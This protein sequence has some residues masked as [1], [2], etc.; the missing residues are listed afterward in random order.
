ML[1]DEPLGV[2]APVPTAPLAHDLKRTRVKATA[3]STIGGECTRP[4][5]EYSPNMELHCE[6]I[7]RSKARGGML[8]ESYRRISVA[9]N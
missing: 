3:H 5:G 9:R 8:A 4:I 2:K 1:G 7:D 6:R